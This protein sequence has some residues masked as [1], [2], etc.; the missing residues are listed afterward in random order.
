[1]LCRKR[2]LSVMV[3][4]GRSFMCSLSSFFTF[5]SAFG[6]LPGLFFGASEFPDEPSL[7]S[8]FM[9]EERLTSKRRAA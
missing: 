1:M 8:A 3:A 4:A 2:I 9:T 7:S 6:G 5:S